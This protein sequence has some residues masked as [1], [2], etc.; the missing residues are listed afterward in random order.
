MADIG[1]KGFVAGQFVF[2]RGMVNFVFKV[3]DMEF[4]FGGDN[5]RLLTMRQVINL[6]LR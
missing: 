2:Y 3:V 1:Y 6:F 4:L 5:Y